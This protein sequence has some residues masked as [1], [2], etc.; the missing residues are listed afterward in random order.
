ML[1][2]IKL[3]VQIDNKPVVSDFSLSIKPGTVHALMGPNGAG[4]SSLAHTLAGDPSY[5]VITGSVLFDG[6]DITNSLPE[7]RAQKGMFLAFQQPPAIPGVTIATFMREACRAVLK[8]ESLE[9]FTLRLNNALEMVGLPAS[10][11]ARNLNEGFSGGEKKRLEMMQL[12]LLKPKFVILDEIDSGLDID[13]LRQIAQSLSYV[14]RENPDMSILIVTH[15]QRILDH[16]IPDFVHVMDGGRLVQSGDA[17]LVA[18]IEQGGYGVYRQ[19]A[20]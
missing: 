8:E 19:Q 18:R 9:Q 12:I 4:K 15:Y 17:S 20:S 6:I 13:A 3:T 1:S 14:R 16:I 5:R 10:C 2:I 11:A 7:E